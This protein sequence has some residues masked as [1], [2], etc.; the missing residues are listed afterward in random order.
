MFISKKNILFQG[1]RGD[2]T[3]SRGFKLFSDGVQ[4]LISTETHITFDCAA[5]QTKENS[6]C[7]HCGTSGFN[8]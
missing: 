4:I 8:I 3:F 5:A 2:P 7:F 6:H 1:L